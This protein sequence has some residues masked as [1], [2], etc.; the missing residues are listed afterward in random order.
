MDECLRDPGGGRG[1]GVMD[2]GTGDSLCH[3]DPDTDSDTCATD[4]HQYPCEGHT[5]GQ[6]R[7]N[8]CDVGPALVRCMCT[9]SI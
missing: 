6:C 2:Q 9:H 5:P 7:A 8:V 4:G 1:G 3:R